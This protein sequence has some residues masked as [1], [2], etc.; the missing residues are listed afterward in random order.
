M[1]IISKKTVAIIVVNWNGFAF[2]KACL[3][4]LRKIN[5]PN[6]QV[7][8]IDNAS[9]RPEGEDLKREF[10][11]IHLIQ[12]N[13]NLG[14][15]GGNNLGIRHAMS[16]GFDY[17][18]LLNNDTVV[19]PDFLDG[20]VHFLDI[21]PSYAAVQPKIRFALDK[22]KIWNAGGGY[23]K[24]LEMSWSVGIGK[25]DEGQFDVARNI[26]WI[27]GC[28]ILVKSDAIREA[29][30]LDED[31][32]AYYEDVEWSFRFR[33]K[34]LK[35]FYLPQSIIYHV[36]GASSKLKKTKEGKVSPIVHYLRTRNHLYLIRKHGTPFSFA[37]SLIYQ[38]LRNAAFV[39]F[40]LLRGRTKK[41]KAILAGHKMGLFG[42]INDI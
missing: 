38:S 28:A 40:L 19:E 24:P 39:V 4:S 8:L 16:Q 21:N 30:M 15:T 26:P 20:L 1:A 17:V 22:N 13:S 18:L 34:D 33:K 23:F 5:Y 11:E 29:G 41:A 12:A 6:F 27:T 10:P 31:F 37:L 2:T 9:I 32:F 35:L 7:L 3:S 36:A 25:K 42:K 14:F